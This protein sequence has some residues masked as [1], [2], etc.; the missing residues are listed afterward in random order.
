[1]NTDRLTIRTVVITLAG[2]VLGGVG[3]M[4]FLTAIHIPIPD[5]LDRVVSL[6]LG[7]IVGLLAKTSSSD[8]PPPIVNTPIVNEPD[9]TVPTTTEGAT[10]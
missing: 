9:G 6:A 2:V 4:V 10:P 8:T 7:G 5:Q 1:M 3:S